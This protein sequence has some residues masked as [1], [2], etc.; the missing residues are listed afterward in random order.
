LPQNPSTNK[1]IRMSCRAGA[2]E[3]PDPTQPVSRADL[4]RQEFSSFGP[5]SGYREPRRYVE[6]RMTNQQFSSFERNTN[7]DL[8]SLMRTH[9]VPCDG[10]QSSKYIRAKKGAPYRFPGHIRLTNPSDRKSEN[11]TNKSITGI[12]VPPPARPAP[13]ISTVR[14][15]LTKPDEYKSGPSQPATKMQSCRDQWSRM[16]SLRMLP[17]EP[18]SNP[19]PPLPKY[20]T[21]RNVDDRAHAVALHLSELSM[22]KPHVCK[23]CLK[24]FR[25]KGNLNVHLRIHTGEK[26][27]TCNACQ[28]PFS[29]L[30]NMKRHYARRHSSMKHIS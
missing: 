3:P 28:R 2:H 1:V 7:M 22:V 30:S 21:E 25:Q 27:Y 6:N 4:I 23:F 8:S 26:P 17:P 15:R 18:P 13:T 10:L 9:E 12:T 29:Q 20:N 24:G 11:T 19:A 14:M 5:E 16:S